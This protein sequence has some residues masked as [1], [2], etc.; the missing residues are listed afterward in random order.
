[1]SISNMDILR[2]DLNLL[3]Y[4]KQLLKHLGLVRFLGSTYMS[5]P[6]LH[7]SL[8]NS[9]CFNINSPSNTGPV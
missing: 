8:C 6:F 2:G 9:L 5:L 1:M 3:D 4:S 7:R